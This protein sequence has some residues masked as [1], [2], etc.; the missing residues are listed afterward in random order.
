MS[1]ITSAVL[2]EKKE[3]KTKFIDVFPEMLGPDGLPKPDIFVEDRLH[4]NAEGYKLW[5][6]I[7]AP[8]LPTPDR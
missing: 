4:M 8:L 5:T 6:G 2:S 3:Q 7:I 1:A